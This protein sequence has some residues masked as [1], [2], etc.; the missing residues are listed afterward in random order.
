M[1]KQTEKI[2]DQMLKEIYGADYEKYREDIEKEVDKYGVKY[3]E[4]EV[5]EDVNK[6]Q[7]IGEEF[8]MGNTFDAQQKRERTIKILLIIGGI[9][10]LGGTSFFLY[11]KG[12][13][14]KWKNKLKK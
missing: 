9:L 10:A 13:F 5:G 2:K 4:F 7:N 3:T 1:S 14:E 6:P 8:N 11:K 12:Y